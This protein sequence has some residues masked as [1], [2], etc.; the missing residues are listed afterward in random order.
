[1]YAIRSYYV[2][3]RLFF[4]L[5]IPPKKTVNELENMVILQLEY[6]HLIGVIVDGIDR[7]VGVSKSKIQPSHPLFGDVN[8]EYIRGVVENDGKLYI[9]LDVE[10]IV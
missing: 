8:I 10:K 4:G 2:D 9:I 5:E 7:V 3:L 1:M 6:G